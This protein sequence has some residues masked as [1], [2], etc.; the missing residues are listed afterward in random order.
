MCL[1]IVL[2]M[3]CEGDLPV[4]NRAVYSIAVIES[5]SSIW[6]NLAKQIW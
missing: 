4:R 2:D 6:S 5:E 1:S 3:L